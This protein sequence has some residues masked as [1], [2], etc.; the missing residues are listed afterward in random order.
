MFQ[1][2][3][4]ANQVIE[5]TF[6]FN[7]PWN[8]KLIQFEVSTTGQVKLSEIHKLSESERLFFANMVR[9]SNEIAQASDRTRL[10][11]DITRSF[12]AEKG[13]KL[14]KF[15]FLASQEETF[16]RYWINL[17]PLLP[18]PIANL[19]PAVNLG[20]DT[21][22]ALLL[23]FVFADSP[24]LL[25]VAIAL[26]FFTM[27]NEVS[28]SSLDNLLGKPFNRGLQNGF[29][30]L[31]LSIIVF[32]STRIL[33]RI[34]SNQVLKLNDLAA[35]KPANATLGYISLGI[36][37]IAVLAAWFVPYG[38]FMTAKS[39]IATV[40]FTDE[41]QKI[42]SIAKGSLSK[43]LTDEIKSLQTTSL[44][45][46]L[47]DPEAKSSLPLP[48]HKFMLMP[49]T[50][51]TI[52]SRLASAWICSEKL[53]LVFKLNRGIPESILLPVAVMS[54]TQCLWHQPILLHCNHKTMVKIPGL[55]AVLPSF[56][57][58]LKYTSEACA[59][60]YNSLI[61]PST[62]FIFIVE[63][64]LK[65]Y[66]IELWSADSFLAGGISL[67]CLAFLFNLPSMMVDLAGRRFGID[68]FDDC[69]SYGL[70][71]RVSEAKTLGL[72]TQMGTYL[73]QLLQ[74]AANKAPEELSSRQNSLS[75]LPS[76]R[77]G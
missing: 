63:R 15:S 7:L 13:P 19:V 23:L 50:H 45:R 64:M 37:S 60:S 33:A 29:L 76:A 75:D 51:L 36:A 74:D 69:S 46:R 44:A 25:Y 54:L 14:A 53:S 77:L 31:T 18:L 73:Q 56:A 65:L 17:P 40:R 20:I 49:P 38:K 52:I 26:S 61:N 6:S 3:N 12:R 2:L 42:K 72:K 62:S 59:I 67:L 71:Q 16:D 66:G 4:P 8:R 41:C 55:S 47:F 28:S 11:A 57:T 22:A 35:D 21:L 58:V 32:S 27:L 34:I 30:A 68:R 24:M 9:R 10:I 39:Q 1:F 43:E 48:S 5:K 70:R